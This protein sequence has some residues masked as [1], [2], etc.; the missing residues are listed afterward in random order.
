M[1]HR[2]FRA[3][4]DFLLLRSELSEVDRD[5]VDWWTEIQQREADQQLEMV[6]TLKQEREEDGEFPDDNIGN[7]IDGPDRNTSGNTSANRT[8]QNKNKSRGR[9]REQRG[10][11]GRVVRIMVKENGQG[12]AKGSGQSRRRKRPGKR[13]AERTK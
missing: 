1:G 6:Q 3:A 5:I 10:F 2:R 4:Y 11:T 12:Q 8:R 9:G 7:R 13:G